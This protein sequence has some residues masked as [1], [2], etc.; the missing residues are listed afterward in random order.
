MTPVDSHVWL[1]ITDWCVRALLPGTF[2]RACLA[3]ILGRFDEARGGGR[4][5]GGG[6]SPLSDVG[7]A[8]A[9]TCDEVV[10]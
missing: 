5:R 3:N 1:G 2:E 6:E 4:R 9:I 8:G 10:L 7:G